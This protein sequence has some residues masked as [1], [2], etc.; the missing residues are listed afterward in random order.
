MV[1]IFVALL[2]SAL[3][4]QFFALTGEA[5]PMR[6]EYEQMH[7]GTLFRIVL[8]SS[9]ALAA[10]EAARRAFFR[11]EQLEAVM[12]SYRE[13]SELRAV[14]QHA[15]D[16][17]QVLSPDLYA[18]LD[19]SLQLSR[20]MGG[21]FDITVRPFVLMWRRARD[22]GVLPAKN[23]LSRESQRVG[24]DLILLNPRTQSLRF[25]VPRV[26]LDLGGIGKGYA[27]DEALA[28][29]NECQL[30]SALVYAGGDI[31]VGAP[32]PG[33]KG[34]SVALG[35]GVKQGREMS[36][37]DCAIASSGDAYQFVEIEGIRYSHIIDPR[38]GLGVVGLRK[39]TVI[40]PEATTADALAT[41]LS[42][43]G[44]EEGFRR[45]SSLDGVSAE[46]VHYPNGVRN[47]LWSE[48]FP[49]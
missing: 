40:A 11:I 15:F 39:A 9:D 30:P 12:S 43:L 17:P 16:S 38:T 24:F 26:E 37:K 27:A 18:V 42:I 28:V 2:V 44:P 22:E 29:L 49:Q 35:E 47:A 31:R 4:I 7:M 32:P 36:L 33:R 3:F 46:F 21:A 1:R 25:R 34:W 13:D 8:Y 20:I 10:Q 14:Q 41:A 6:Y 23:L 5:I 19:R 45:I 48:G